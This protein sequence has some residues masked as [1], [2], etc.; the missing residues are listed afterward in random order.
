MTDHITETGV[1]GAG[2]MGRDIAGLLANAGYPVTQVD[3][4]AEVLE[5]AR[6]YH[7]SE[8]P[9]ELRATSLEN[10]RDPADR[11]A[12]DTDVAALAGTDFVVE[13]VP[14]SL[15]LKREVA[16]SL[17]DVLSPEA[18]IGTNT[19]SLTPGEIAAGLEHPERVVLFHF[20]NPALRRDLVEIAGDDATDGALETAREVASA[21]DREPIRLEREYRANGL[22]RLSASIKC[23]ATWELLE[24]DVAAVDTGAQAVGFDR[25]PLELIDLIGLDVH[26]ATVDN[27]E[28]AYGDRYTPPAEVRARVERLVREGN[29]GK[30][31]GA[32]FFEWDG[33]TCLVPEPDEP[34][35]VTPIL[36][37]LVNEGN[38]LVA[39]GIA[40]PATVDEI[41]KRGGDSEVGPFDLQETFG[42]EFL[43]NAL[44]TRYEETGASIYD[45]TF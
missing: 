19:S 40:D 1:V 41:L 21:I 24:A 43:R 32:G 22:S 16:A 4:D 20:A 23:A 13:A 15:A 11:I 3:V 27:L 10:R 14:E 35:D 42:D 39:D 12:Y 45:P 36:A 44:E 25:G 8:L 26:L 5:D 28:A 37:A 17:E 29:L 6:T 31:S 18:V 34:H 2:L 38:R 9:A 33:S 7:E 30:K